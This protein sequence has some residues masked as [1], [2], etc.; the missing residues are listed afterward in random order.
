M[1]AT[2]WPKI[3][4]L[5]G[6]LPETG[7]LVLGGRGTGKSTF[8]LGYLQAGLAAGETALLVCNRPA[9][10]A[11]QHAKAFGISLDEAVRDGQ[12]TLFEYPE[13]IGDN[14]ANLVDDG[15]VAEELQALIGG[16]GVRR[17]VFDPVTPL[18]AGS[19]GESATHRLRALQQGLSEL[20]ATT[21]FVL[22]T[23]SGGD[24]L[25]AC[26]AAIPAVL[27][28]DMAGTPGGNTRS[29]RLEGFSGERDRAT[30]YFELVPGVGLEPL[31]GLPE[32]GAS[33]TGQTIIAPLPS[34]PSVVAGRLR[35]PP[36][37]PRPDDLPRLEWAPPLRRVLM[38]EP[39]ARRRNWL[40]QL[41]EGDYQLM[42]AHHAA[43]GLALASTESP[44]AII[45]ND[46]LRGVSG[47]E[48]IRRLR[49][50]G[51]TQPIVAIGTRL[52]RS[53]DRVDA[54]A[55][56]ADSCFALPADGRLIRLSL[57][58]LSNRA[59]LP[60]P[61][62]HP[63]S[64]RFVSPP[65][66]AVSF[67]HSAGYLMQRIEYEAE[68]APQSGVRFCL[69]A[70]RPPSSAPLD[71]LA[72]TVAILSRNVDLSFTGSRGLVALLAEAPSE[73]PFLARFQQRWKGGYQPAVEVL[74]YEPGPD[75]LGKARE[76]VERVCDDGSSSR[77]SL[78]SVEMTV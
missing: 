4:V 10:Q 77:R 36:P 74:R 33:P 2:A 53:S 7:C 24:Y 57:H 44:D 61:W 73:T 60:G 65:R 25:A 68:W 28:F 29:L 56:G 31:E 70:M 14:L 11:L 8:A 55:A 63:E 18:L 5:T 35:L 51:C 62:N 72:S 50:S 13:N 48:V 75:F 46:E 45:I 38:L 32:S 21:L 71:E 41:L 15:R 6:G 3:D 76:F 20:G 52:A 47:R 59:A 22:D 58:N 30:T 42:E 12:L 17:A 9:R 78:K 64:D 26:R 39:D 19:G 34:S 49:R 16:R 43:D 69:V 37:Q 67:T 54:L 27:R 1:A 66:D 23:A 40:R